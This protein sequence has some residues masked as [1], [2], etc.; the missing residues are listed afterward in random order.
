MN[1][2]NL[3]DSVRIAGHKEAGNLNCASIAGFTDKDWNIWQ[4]YGQAI[5]TQ[6]PVNL[7][8]GLILAAKK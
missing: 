6:V 7:W 4:N 2:S 8:P 3:A 1:S 5:E